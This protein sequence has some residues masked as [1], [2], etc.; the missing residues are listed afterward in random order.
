[1]FPLLLEDDVEHVRQCRPDRFTQTPLGLRTPVAAATKDRQRSAA[2]NVFSTSL[3]KCFLY[4]RRSKL[5][6]RA[7]ALWRALTGTWGPLRGLVVA[8]R[9]N[10]N[11]IRAATPMFPCSC[12]RM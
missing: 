2:H 8:G 1:M 3:R 10:A 12:P 9:V 5:R 11:C 7:C 4:T 6:A